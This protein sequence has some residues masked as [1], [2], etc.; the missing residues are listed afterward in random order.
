LPSNKW[1]FLHDFSSFSF[2][3]KIFH[4]FE[5]LQFLFLFLFLQRRREE[6]L[7]WRQATI[8]Y[9]DQ[10]TE[11][12]ATFCQWFLQIVRLNHAFDLGVQCSHA[13]NKVITPIFVVIIVVIATT[14]IFRCA[15]LNRSINNRSS[16]SWILTA[17]PFCSLESR[18]VPPDFLF[19][20]D[21]PLT[22]VSAGTSLL[23][24]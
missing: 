6:L 17:L 7:S 23:P 1:R 24:S 21:F 5:I 20:F 4:R 2:G 22:F 15:I 13:W 19:F 14:S 11:L 10:T 12:I 8:K 9:L 3:K 16:Q 18:A